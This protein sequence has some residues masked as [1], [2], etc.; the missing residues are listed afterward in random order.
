MAAK[1]PRSETYFPGILIRKV[2]K[3]MTNTNFARTPFYGTEY[4]VNVKGR[5]RKCHGYVLSV[6]L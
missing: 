1:Y 3:T 4:D 5:R 2:A 6:K